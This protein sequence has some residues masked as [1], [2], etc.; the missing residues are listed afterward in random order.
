MIKSIVFCQNCMPGS[1]GKFNVLC[2]NCT[3]IEEYR[4]TELEITEKE[5]MGIK[6]G[7][8][9]QPEESTE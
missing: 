7:T 6:T 2:W 3:A 5:Q 4:N 9:G 8:P 1:V